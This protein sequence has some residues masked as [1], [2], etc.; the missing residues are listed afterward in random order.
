MFAIEFFAQF[1]ILN[2]IS[3]MRVVIFFSCANLLW[4]D[5]EGYIAWIEQQ[6]KELTAHL[7]SAWNGGHTFEQGL[8]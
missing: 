5:L 4:F 2:R 6:R 7:L 8:I 1:F 3:V